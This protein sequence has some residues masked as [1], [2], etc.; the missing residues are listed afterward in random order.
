MLRIAKG[1]PGGGF[2]LAATLIVGTIVAARPSGGQIGAPG[3]DASTTALSICQKADQ[4]EGEERTRL[5]AHGLTL[6][7]KAVAADESDGKAHFAV[8][9]NLGKQM[10]EASVFRQTLVVHR[11]KRELELAIALEPDDPQMLIARGAFLV[12]LPAALG[13]D[14][15][16]G[17]ALLR[18]A[19]TK[20][21]NN[22]T[23]L[24]YLSSR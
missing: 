1:R 15:E 9:C 10:Q 3:A 8:F 17:R 12:E 19:L 23:A 2:S 5:L 18:A 21:P 13:G 11:L 14:A 20:D 24:R 16:K 22:H 6:A 7:E 4:S